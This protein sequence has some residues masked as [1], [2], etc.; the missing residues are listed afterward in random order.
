MTDVGFS[1]SKVSA[2]Y[3]AGYFAK[4]IWELKGFHNRRSTIWW[5]IVDV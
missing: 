2:G 4:W 1:W 5:H 3:F